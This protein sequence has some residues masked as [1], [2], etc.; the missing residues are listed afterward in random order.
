MVQRM[1]EQSGVV[2]RVV[3]QHALY[4]LPN[5]QTKQKHVTLPVPK[6]LSHGTLSPE[7]HRI[8]SVLMVQQEH[9]QQDD[10]IHWEVPL[11]GR[12]FPESSRGC[13]RLHTTKASVGHRIQQHID[14]DGVRLR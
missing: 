11:Q 9:Q 5:Q 6:L 2:P 13:A 14:A 3:L 4:P 7:Q 1:E 12:Y 8:L 10:E